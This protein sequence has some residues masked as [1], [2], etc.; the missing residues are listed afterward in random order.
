[1]VLDRGYMMVNL[2]YKVLDLGYMVVN[3][4]YMVVDLGCN[5]GYIVLDLGGMVLDL[6][7]IGYMC[8]DLVVNSMDQL[9]DQMADLLVVDFTVQNKNK[10]HSLFSNRVIIH[11]LIEALVNH[12]R[13]L[14][15]RNLNLP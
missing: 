4:G 12:N 1:M 9:M 14:V 7:C 15:K 10:Q 6:G 5:L 13:I 3:L 8:L 2:G 11:I